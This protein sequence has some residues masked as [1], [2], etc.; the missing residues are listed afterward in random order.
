MRTRF[1]AVCI[2]AVV[3]AVPASLAQGAEALYQGR[4]AGTT[5]MT[6]D[7]HTRSGFGGDTGVSLVV[8]TGKVW[9]GSETVAGEPVYERRTTVR[10]GMTVVEVSTTPFAPVASPAAPPPAVRPDQPAPW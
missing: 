8:P 9:V 7:R 2:A 10:A 4:S 3:G 1:L 5:A 6:P